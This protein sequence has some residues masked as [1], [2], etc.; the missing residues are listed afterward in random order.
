MKISVTLLD[1]GTYIMNCTS[2]YNNNNITLP[3][4]LPVYID[5]SASNF[6]PYIQKI[7]GMNNMDGVVYYS[8]ERGDVYIVDTCKFEKMI[9][10]FQCKARTIGRKSSWSIPIERHEHSQIFMW[11]SYDIAIKYFTQEK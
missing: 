4:E 5:D 6:I 11:V 7:L 9:S 8:H 2:T 1:N 3:N 10:N